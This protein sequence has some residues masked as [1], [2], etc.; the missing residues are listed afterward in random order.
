MRYI[1]LHYNYIYI[2]I[3]LYMCEQTFSLSMFL[4]RRDINTM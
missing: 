4:S 3:Y 1:N 2:S